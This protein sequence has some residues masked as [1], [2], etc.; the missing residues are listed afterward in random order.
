MKKII[1]LLILFIGFYAQAE[2]ISQA[3]PTAQAESAQVETDREEKISFF[4]FSL[5]V[6][7]IQK[8]DLTHAKTLDM[9]F[10]GNISQH[11][12]FGAGVKITSDNHLL[13][14]FQYAYSF[15]KDKKWIPGM[16]F[17]L[18]IGYQ[19]ST[20]PRERKYLTTGYK[21]PYTSNKNNFVNNFELGPYLKIFISK[22][23]ALLLRTGISGYNSTDS[24]F[25]SDFIKKSK[26][27]L[28]LGLQWYF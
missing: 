27:Y 28:N 17:S 2:S 19:I 20:T 12:S 22:S 23:H 21:H 10:G 18:L 25:H 11:S 14:G 7:V 16:D 1:I 4:S 24:F 15:T 13:L 8:N 6:E 26:I 3:E 9:K 5:G